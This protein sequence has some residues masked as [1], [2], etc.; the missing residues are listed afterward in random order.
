MINCRCFDDD[1]KTQRVLLL[2]ADTNEG[3]G[4]C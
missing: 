1:K 4:E 2:C 3:N